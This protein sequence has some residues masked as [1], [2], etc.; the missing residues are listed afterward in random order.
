MS[1]GWNLFG[2]T[3]GPVVGPAVGLRGSDSW[4]DDICAVVRLVELG[5]VQSTAW[6]YAVANVSSSFT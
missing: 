4:V 1:I 6:S 2:G 3:A 5:V